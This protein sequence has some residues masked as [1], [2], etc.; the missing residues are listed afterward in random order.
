MNFRTWSFCFFLIISLFCY[1]K[2]PK[3]FPWICILISSVVFYAFSGA[4]NLIFILFSSFLTFYG[5]K[6]ITSYN[7]LLKEKKSV[8]PKEDF[9]VERENIKHIKRIVL[10]IVLILNIGLLA[11]LKYWNAF[12]SFLGNCF[13]LNFDFLK[14]SGFRGILLPLGI[15]FYTF[16]TTAYFMDIYNGKYENEKNFLKY[17]TFVSF[18]PQLIMGPI[19]RFD[20]LGIQLKEEHEFDFENIKHGV[21]LILFGAMKKYCIADLLYTRISSVLD[22]PYDNLPGSLIA[23]GILAFSIYQYAD[24]SGGIDMVLGIS[25]LFGL[26]MQPNFKQPYFAR[27]LADFWRRWHISLGLWMKDYVF[28]PLALTHFMQNIGKFF[29][30]HGGKKIGK[31]LARTVPAGIANIVVFLLVG[32]WHGPELHFVLW[33]LYNG[34]VIAFSDLFKPAFEKL[35]SILHIN[36]KSKSFVVF[37]IVR[38]FIV[39]NIGAYFDRITDVKKCFLYLKQTFFNFGTL[40]IYKSQAYLKSVFGSFRYVE[41]ELVLIISASIIVFITSF[42]KENKVDLYTAIQKKNIAFRWS[43]YYVP[44]ILV[45]LSMSFSPSNPVFMYAQY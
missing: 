33:G 11:Y 21:L 31:H 6:K 24:F 22:H 14:F 5:A 25:K 13:L 42:L 1:Y 39:V 36:V 28:Y 16:Q 37:Q 17:F 35:S 43:A 15:S 29:S 40:E 30:A 10:L 34:L 32:I 4:V 18:F 7:L 38:T 45:I 3:K 41:S 23:F 9:K 26:E 20:K 12:V 19:N 27:N 44:L 2:L 8:L